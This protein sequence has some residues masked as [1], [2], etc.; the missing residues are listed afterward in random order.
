M[1]AGDTNIFLQI[2]TIGT[3]SSYDY[4]SHFMENKFIYQMTKAVGHLIHRI[5]KEAGQDILANIY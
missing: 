4:V 2:L 1:T 3:Q 5:L